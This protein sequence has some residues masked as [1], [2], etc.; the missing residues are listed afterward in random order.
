MDI[1]ESVPEGETLTAWRLG[2][3]ERSLE[4]IAKKLDTFANLREVLVVHSEKIASLERSRDRL[5]AGISVVAT[6]TVM[7]ILNLFFEVVK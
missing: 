7:L 5:I 6:G 2:R 4:E 1:T 3:V